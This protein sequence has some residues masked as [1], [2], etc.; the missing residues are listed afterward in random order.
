[1]TRCP[2]DLEL[3]EHLLAGAPSALGTHLAA[4]ARCAARLEQ[5]RR[6]GEEFQREVFPATVAAVLE[7]S[8]ARVVSLPRRLG[9]V[10]APFAA[11]AAAAAFVVFA[12]RPPPA[13]VGAKG[14]ALNL[15]VYVQ[16][17]GGARAAVDGDAV[18]A[19][20]AVRFHVRPERACRLWIVSVDA[21]G[22]VSRLYPAAGDAEEVG[23][24][25]TLPGGARLDGRAGPER[26]FAVCSP[27]PLPFAEVERAAQ[28]TA[29]RGA[30]SVRAAR[31]LSG[32]P[33]DAAQATLLLE[34]RP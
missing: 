34:K 27:R 22:Q 21:V 4:C 11:A 29:G 5:M 6:E 13:Y 9:V 28:A 8:R 20:A 33:A 30:E 7:G 19:A 16:T 10:L 2:S 32:L 12:A 31:A 24:P 17:A 23:A 3:E 14:G 18:P 15:A 26:L 1:V 25:A